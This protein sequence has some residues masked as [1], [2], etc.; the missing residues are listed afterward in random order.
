MLAND[1]VSIREVEDARVAQ[2]VRKLPSARWVAG[3]TPELAVPATAQVPLPPQDFPRVAWLR[4]SV[5]WLTFAALHAVIPTKLHNPDLAFP[6]TEV[7]SIQALQEISEVEIWAT[8]ALHIAVAIGVSVLGMK[9][10]KATLSFANF[11]AFGVGL[12][13]IIAA[14]GEA[15]LLQGACTWFHRDTDC[16][17]P[18]VLHW[19]LS[20][21][22]RF[23]PSFGTALN[24]LG[25]A[26][27]PSVC[28]HIG[29]PG[30]LLVAIAAL[31][32]LYLVAGFGQS[33][34]ALAQEPVAE[35]GPAAFRLTSLT[36]LFAAFVIN[37][38]PPF[39]A[40]EGTQQK[41]HND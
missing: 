10:G 41:E 38:V 13:V 17:L 8:A 22:V 40:V 3:L 35:V 33:W 19:I 37:R 24:M 31:P 28:T 39:K 9:L 29:I 30:F 18:F 5:W 14:V 2:R 15:V 16:F 21:V 11:V 32:T 27:A 20:C 12:L 34:W 7:G 1:D 25:L 6:L 4:T 23:G 26:A 36:A